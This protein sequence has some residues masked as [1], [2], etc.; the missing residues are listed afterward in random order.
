[1][2]R[3]FL[4]KRFQLYLDFMVNL[5]DVRDV[6]A[7]L[8]L[9]MERGQTGH[10]YILGGESIPLKDVLRLVA[11]NSGRRH[12]RI[13]VP[14]RIAQSAAA[15]LEFIADHVT[16]KPPSGTAEGVRIALRASS[17]SIEKAQRELGYTPRAV[18]PALRETIAFLLDAAGDRR[19]VS[20]AE[21][22]RVRP[23]HAGRRYGA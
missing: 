21:P 14:G 8:V 19:H 4:G 12:L 5:V 13:S 10:R 2:L 20:S 23:A 17:L 6:A 9:A 22:R 16:G 3:H 1:M 15:M 11:A 18:E 7:G